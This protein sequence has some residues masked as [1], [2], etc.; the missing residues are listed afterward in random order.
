MIRLTEFIKFH[1]RRQ[2]AR[3]TLSS[4]FTLGLIN[5]ILPCGLVY[6][7][8]AT[9]ATLGG[10]IQGGLGMLAFG[11]GTLPMMFGL[12]LAGPK[13]QFLLKLK[14]RAF[15]PAG[16]ALIGTFLILRGLDFGPPVVSAATGPNCLF[17][18]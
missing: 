5:G 8:C 15:V 13:L 2:L 7:G 1:F 9:A 4:V 10:P 16:V 3:R 17:C 12:S 14:L 11:I 18:R 6:A